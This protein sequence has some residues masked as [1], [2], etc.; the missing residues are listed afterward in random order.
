MKKTVPLLLT[1]S[2]LAVFLTACGLSKPTQNTFPPQ[3]ETVFRFKTNGVIYTSKLSS[4]YSMGSWDCI[5]TFSKDEFTIES[6]D[7]TGTYKVFYEGKAITEEEFQ[8]H[9]RCEKESIPDITAYKNITQYDLISST[10]DTPGYRLYVLDDTYWMATLYGTSVWRI[11]YME[12][13]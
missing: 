1:I 13:E 12:A 5:Y 7:L 2:L 8:T 11:M 3:E 6:D 4:S 9:F 10:N